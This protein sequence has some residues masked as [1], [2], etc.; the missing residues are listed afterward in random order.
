MDDHMLITKLEAENVKRLTAVSIEPDG[1]VIVGGANDSGKS[2]VLDAIMYALAGKSTIPGR[3]LR[4]GEEHGHVI[5][6]IEGG[7]RIIVTRNFTEKGSTI[8]VTDSKGRTFANPQALLD[9][10]FGS[11][12][13]DPVAFLRMKPDKQAEALRAAA[14]IDLTQVDEDIALA[15]GRRT[16]S[17]RDVK[18]LQARVDGVEVGGDVPEALV[19]IEALANLQQCRQSR[20]R[21]RPRQPHQS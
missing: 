3:P 18:T 21:S 17:N 11:L 9:S 15:F 1:H 19:D 10:L 5:V 16:D 2:S 13:F 8:K 12:T 20:R 7:E 4:D 14:G 6:E